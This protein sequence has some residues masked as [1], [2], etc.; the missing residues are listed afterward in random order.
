M[1]CPDIGKNDFH[2]T[3]KLAKSLSRRH[4]IKIVGPIFETCYGAGK[5]FIEDPELDITIIDPGVRSRYLALTTPSLIRK[6]L[7][8]CDGDIIH[9]FKALPHTALTAVLAKYTN[10]KP[11][12]VDL[13]D[14]ELAISSNAN[15]TWRALLLATEQSLRLCDEITVTSSFLQKRFGGVLVPNGVDTEQFSFKVSGEDVRRE[16]GISDSLVVGYVG[17]LKYHKGVDLLIKAVLKAQREMRNLKV[18]IVGTSPEEGYIEYLKQISD[19]NVIFAGWRPFK[20]I[21]QYLAACDIIAIPNRNTLV[22]QAQ[23]PTKLFE[24]MALGKPVITTDVGDMP[25]ILS[26][27]N[28]LVVRAGDID[29]LKKGILKILCDEEYAKSLGKNARKACVSKYSC[30]VMAEIVE[31]IYKR[32]S[33]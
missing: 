8:F 4:E 3:Y 27:G 7:E 12:V 1:V 15:F 16:L 28:G 18:L 14:W 22:T 19:D 11:V 23:V 6:Q 33:I 32:I 13:E 26:E 29:G 24:A 2:R 25:K 21:P 10:S 31:R 5:P 30:N 17:T 9:A 20:D